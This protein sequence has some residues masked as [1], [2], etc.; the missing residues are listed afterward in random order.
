MKKTLLA[1]TLLIGSAVSSFAETIEVEMLNQ[2]E[3][4]DRM[5]FSQE[6]IRAEVGDVIRFIP[7]DKS[8]NA[9]SVK[10]ALP[11]GQEEF[12][13]RMNQEVEYTVTETGL[14]AVICLPHQVMGMVALVVV[15]D[16]TSNADQILEARIP[17]K[18]MEKIE[19]L[20]EEARASAPAAED[21]SAKDS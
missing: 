6:L 18:G 13:G 1:T 10:D 19:A 17:G 20:I 12:R 4:G 5:V 21:A 11:A 16:D 8:H 2:N 9:Q 3:A 15:G 14:T 7:T